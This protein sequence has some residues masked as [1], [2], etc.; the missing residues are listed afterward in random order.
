MRIVSYNLNGIRS[1]LRKD[2]WSWVGA[3]APDV[4]CLQETKA[5]PDQVPSE[6]LAHPQL[7]HRYWHSAQKKGYSGVAIFSK[8][9]PLHVEVGMGN[10]AFDAEGRVLRV[11]FPKVSVMSVYVPSGTNPDRLAFKFRFMEAF[12]EHIAQL[13]ER[14]PGLVVCGDFNICHRAIDI[15]DPVRNAKVSGFLPQE[16]AWLSEVLAAGFLDS[17]R[18]IHPH[19]ADAYSWW[20]YRAASRVR[21]KGWRIDYQLLS[22]SLRGALVGAEVLTD[23]IHSDHCPTFA[24]FDL[25]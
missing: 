3:V 14:L 23:A 18:A 16:R 8:E 11:D 17:F 12:L 20:S 2:W 24:E 22:L 7:K 1:A 19:R 15:H 9:K 4:L 6:A 10:P 21:N 5:H 25:G 13:Q